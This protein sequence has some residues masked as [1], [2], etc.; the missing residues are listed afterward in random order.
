MTAAGEARPDDEDTGSG[1]RLSTTL[2]LLVAAWGAAVASY[3][4]TDNSFLTHLATGRLILEDGAVPGSDPYTFTARGT[5]WVVQSWLPSTIY[6]AAEQIAGTAGLRAVVLVLTTAAAAVLWLVSRPCT[7]VVP[8]LALVLA[9]LYIT[10]DLWGERPYMVGVVG[11]GLVWLA[12][13][14]RLPP[15]TLVPSFWIWANSHGSYALGVALVAL[16]LLGRWLDGESVDAER[17]VL[18]WSIAGVLS[19][20]VGPLGLEVLLFPLTALTKSDILREIVEWK[21]ATYRSLDQ[22]LFLVLVA[23]TLLAVVRRRSWRFALPAIAFSLAAVVAQRN[24]VMAVMVLVPIAAA[25]LPSFGTLRVDRRPVLGRAYV[26]VGVA[27]LALAASY[28]VGQPFGPLSAYPQYP[29]AWI[30]ADDVEARIATP[31]VVGNLLTNLDGADADVFVDDRVDMLPE[32]LVRD[33]ITLLRGAPAWSAVLEEYQIDVVIWS[34]DRPLRQIVAA[35]ERWR[36]VL[37]DRQW[38][39]ACRRGPGCD[40]LER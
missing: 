18:A 14:G 12:L 22:Q 26:F 10:T 8:R 27:S 39:L 36:V 19:A 31:D 21:P 38:T 11:L 20:V 25:S 28:S 5:D 23:V 15:W 34:R 9:G 3:P 30:G 40:S 17:R 1:P 7:S 2:G 29:L 16:A 32:D 33:S 35:D 13:D 37:S 24:I 4:L 6:A